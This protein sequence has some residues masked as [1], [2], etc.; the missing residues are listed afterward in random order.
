MYVVKLPWERPPLSLN[1]RPKH[2]AQHATLVQHVRETAAILTR[3][4]IYNGALIPG[5]QIIV[6]LVWYIPTLARRDEDNP[7]ATL[8]PL[9]DG[10]V[11][12]GLVPDDTPEWMAKRPVRFIYRK[13]EPGMELWVESRE[14]VVE[15]ASRVFMEFTN[16]ACPGAM[17]SVT[18]G[19]RAA[20]NAVLNEVGVVPQSSLHPNR[21]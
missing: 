9:C 8:K 7:V 20:M 10:L 19:L 2:W 14:D 4:A 16:R 5:T 17:V 21:E 13:R 3:N 11:D 18:D 15:R 12:A 6:T 1:D